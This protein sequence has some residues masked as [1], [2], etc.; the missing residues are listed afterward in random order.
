MR[1]LVLATSSKGGAGIA[2]LR[3]YEALKIAGH[4]V[5]F[6]SNDYKINLTCKKRFKLIEIS[7][8]MTRKVLTFLQMSFLQK[9]DNLMTPISVNSILGLCKSYATNFDVIHIH[10]TYNL[11]TPKEIQR[12]STGKKVVFTLHDERIYTGGCHYVENCL[13]FANACH[14][15]PQSNFPFKEIPHFSKLQ[16]IRSLSS[17]VNLNL[18]T[19]SSWLKERAA[20]SRFF[21]DAKIHVVHN[22]VP[23]DFFLKNQKLLFRPDS[24]VVIG[25][26]ATDV[27][28]RYKDFETLLKALEMLPIALKDRIRLTIAAKNTDLI[29]K[30]DFEIEIFSPDSNSALLEFYNHLDF[31]VVPSIQD[32]SPNVIIEALACGT[33]VIGSDTGGIPELLKYFDL[34]TFRKGNFEEL[35]LVIQKIIQVGTPIIDVNHAEILFGYESHASQLERVYLS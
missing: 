17:L 30:R 31:L 19:P 26:I 2:A 20:Q 12:I 14:N 5:S 33:P 22:P 21:K 29:I 28:N 10:A 6:I 4:Q 35:S 16:S 24:K 15:C 32:N 7:Y 9:R 1:V 11:L 18:I 8:R 23:K 34:P 25:F 27:L 3:S 13:N